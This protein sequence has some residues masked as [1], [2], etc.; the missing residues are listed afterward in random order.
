[1][2]LYSTNKNCNVLLDGLKRIA[3]ENTE[4]PLPVSV[5]FLCYRLRI[6]PLEALKHLGNWADCCA[7]TFNRSAKFDRVEVK[8]TGPD[9]VFIIHGL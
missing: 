8:D 7:R 9:Y 5:S 3:S 6:D 2:D 1:M 4:R